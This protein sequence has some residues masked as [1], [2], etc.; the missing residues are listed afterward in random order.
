MIAQ[1]PSAS[2]FTCLFLLCIHTSDAILCNTGVDSTAGPLVDCLTN[3]CM[4]T[5]SPQATVYSCDFSMI[6]QV[7]ELEDACVQD[8]D[9]VVCCCSRDR[10]NF[11]AGAVI[12]RIS[13]Q[14]KGNTSN[15]HKETTGSRSSTP[16]LG[17]SKYYHVN[18]QSSTKTEF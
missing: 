7:I 14:R 13:Q 9:N 6:C 3:Q 8:G 2:L 4:N 12:T 18:S 16:K 11:G 15:F 1:L 17:D 5:T 10:C